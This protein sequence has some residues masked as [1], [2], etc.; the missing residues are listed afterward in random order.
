MERKKLTIKQ[1]R[2]CHE[3]I[4]DFNATQAYIRAK[5]SKTGAQ[6]SASKLLSNPIVQERIKDLTQKLNDKSLDLKQRIKEEL[7]NIAFANASDFFEVVEIKNDD[8]DVTGSY[9]QIRHDVLDSDKLAAISSFE[10]TAYG[11]KIKVNDKQ[12][13]LEMLARHV[14]FFNADTSL[15]PENTNEINLTEV[16]SEKLRALKKVWS[17]K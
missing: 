11:Q 12:K 5:Y 1:E 2:F 7:T 9:R 17:K 14:G 4:I 13:A 15:K 10:Q 16:S 8:G 3:Y 6:S